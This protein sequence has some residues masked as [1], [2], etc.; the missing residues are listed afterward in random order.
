MRY[1]FHSPDVI[2]PDCSRPAHLTLMRSEIRN[3]LLERQVNPTD[4]S[5][6]RPDQT[7]AD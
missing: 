3:S 5:L 1:D 6:I 2:V 7:P 4:Q